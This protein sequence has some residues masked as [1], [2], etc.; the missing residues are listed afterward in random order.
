MADNFN[1][2]TADIIN[3]SEEDENNSLIE[4]STLSQIAEDIIKQS[5]IDPDQTASYFSSEQGKKIYLK[6]ENALYLIPLYSDLANFEPSPPPSIK[7]SVD[8]ISSSF[9][10]QSLDEHEETEENMKQDSSGGDMI[11]ITVDVHD[12]PKD[13]AGKIIDNARVVLDLVQ[14][15]TSSVQE[16]TSHLCE[17]S[18]TSGLRN[19]YKLKNDARK[20]IQQQ[21]NAEFRMRKKLYSGIH[22]NF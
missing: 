17:D 20:K 18:I 14:E 6:Y 9:Y 21:M 13:L 19:Q 10:K 1:I 22:I 5:G 11:T 12:E 2:E 3:I 16:C 15:C 8:N 7:L 4:S